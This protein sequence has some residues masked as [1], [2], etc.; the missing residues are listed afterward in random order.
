[1][2]CADGLSSPMCRCTCCVAVWSDVKL[3]LLGHKNVGKTALFNRYVYDEFGRTSMVTA[4]HTEQCT[5][6]WLAATHSG[7][8]LLRAAAPWHAWYHML[9]DG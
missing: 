6:H 2:R 1:M 5:E 7:L 4:A 3:V 8:V 9:T